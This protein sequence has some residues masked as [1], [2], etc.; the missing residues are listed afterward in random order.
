MATK[1]LV[2]G[3][4]GF[5]G[6]YI[7]KELVE[8]GHV[9]RAIRRSSTLPFFIPSHILE[10]VEWVEGDILDVVSLH[11]AMTGMDAV[12]HAAAKVSF[13]AKER[14]E[15]LK[16]NIEGTA[17]VVNIAI[18]QNVKR[19]VYI[20]SVAAIGRTVSGERINEEKKWPSHGIHTLY[21]I[22][23]YHAEMEVWRG[24]AEGLNA[25]CVNP[26]IILGYGDWSASSCAIFKSIYNGFPWYTTGITGFVGVE[27]VARAAVMVM[28]SDISGERFIVNNENWTFQQMLNAIADGFG[29]KRPHR[30]A[31]RLMGAIAWRLEKVKSLISGKRPLL[32][33]HS[34]VVG[35]SKT[36]FDN[37]K[38]LQQLPQFSFT[39][40]QQSI[41]KACRQYVSQPPPSGN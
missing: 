16:I 28:E 19:F 27:D 3:G 2:T 13:Q 5:L 38:I 23:K 25:V 15:L 34:A 9:V 8:R 14:R 29:K 36:H 6:A 33:K 35:H 12:I 39:P 4:T 1:V 18:E 41:E 17:N 31:T 30:E 20:S 37:S 21:A 11:E 10:K 24:A 40:L 26:S 7:I 32:T 22:S